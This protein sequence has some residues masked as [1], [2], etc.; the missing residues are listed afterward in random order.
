MSRSLVQANAFDMCNLRTDII[1]SPACP[2]L[3]MMEHSV[4]EYQAKT[5]QYSNDND[6]VQQWL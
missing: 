1:P 3:V 5:L 4:A 6:M 2:S